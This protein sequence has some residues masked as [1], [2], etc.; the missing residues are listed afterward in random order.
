MPETEKKDTCSQCGY[1]QVNIS[2]AD[3]DLRT[4]AKKLAG[5]YSRTQPPQAKLDELNELKRRLADNKEVYAGH[6]ADN[7]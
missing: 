7:H 5:K 4:L 6:R 1:M 2:R 3:V